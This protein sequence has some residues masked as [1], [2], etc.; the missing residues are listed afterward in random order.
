MVVP[1]WDDCPDTPPPC[2]DAPSRLLWGTDLVDGERVGIDPIG[3]VGG[4]LY[5]VEAW[6]KVGLYMGVSRAS[7]VVVMGQICVAAR[8]GLFNRNRYESVT[9]LRSIFTRADW[10]MW[11]VK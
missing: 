7:P 11:N 5:R 3:I 10:A 4:R 6:R 1:Q 9:D 2:P 8:E